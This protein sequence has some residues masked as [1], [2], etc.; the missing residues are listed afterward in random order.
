MRNIIN[1]QYNKTIWKISKTIE[2]CTEKQI[3]NNSMKVQIKTIFEKK[4]NRKTKF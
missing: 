1:I 3:N 4:T 2:T